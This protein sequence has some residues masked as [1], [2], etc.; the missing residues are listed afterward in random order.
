MK[1]IIERQRVEAKG[2]PRASDISLTPDAEAMVLFLVEKVP[3]WDTLANYSRALN[4][5]ADRWN[6]YTVFLSEVDKL[7]MDDRGG[8]QGFPFAIVRELNELKTFYI[9]QV[10]PLTMS[11]EI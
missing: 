9:A 8:R 4:R 3:L 5:L 6:E 2:Q 7:L 10:A 11:R 1:E